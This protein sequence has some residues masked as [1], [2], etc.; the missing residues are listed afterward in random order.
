[1]PR[2]IAVVNQK[3]GVAKTTST[4]QIGAGLSLMG[5]KVLL[6]DLDPQGNLTA[7]FGIKVEQFK[8]TLYELLRGEVPVRPCILPLLGGYDVITSDIRLSSIELELSQ[9]SEREK[10]LKKAL[11]PILKQYDYIF[12]DCPPSLTLLTL[13]GLTAAKEVF[14]PLQTEFLA[15]HGVGQLL[16]TIE[17]IRKRLN[18]TLEVTGII[19]T[20]YDHRKTL[21]REVVE[22]I[23]EYFPDKLF[24]T[25]IRNNISLAEAPGYGM[26]I[27][28]YKSS[29]H[30]ALDYTSLCQEIIAQE[31][32][33][34]T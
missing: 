31:Q 9:Q 20:L 6:V 25:R 4:I 12:F 14:I 23:E 5:K 27:Y 10:K 19:T 16:H 17:T 1:M 15:L 34:K 7:S 24:Q 21:N 13:N 26:D 11:E 33:E 3:G 8:V 22:K 28:Q 30:G 32:E 29:S 18:P 2:M